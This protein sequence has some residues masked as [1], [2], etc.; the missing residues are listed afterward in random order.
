MKIASIIIFIFALFSLAKSQL[1]EKNLREEL[2]AMREADQ[3]TRQECVKK[4]ADE[5]LKCFVEI[6]K[7]IDTPNT[8][9]LEE[10]FKQY[11]FPTVQSVGRDGVDA[12]LLLLQH[13]NSDALREKNLKPIKKAFKEKEISPSDYAAFI[14]RFLTHQNKPQIYGSNFDMKNGKLVMSRTKDIKNLDKRRLKI[15]LPPIAE[16]VKIVKEIYNLE[17]ELEE[18]F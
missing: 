5:Q 16:Y 1:P 3:K 6:D 13:S 15:G 8:K 2:L 10:I 17:V 7:T 11:G 14:D 18:K 12:F 9:R 4:N